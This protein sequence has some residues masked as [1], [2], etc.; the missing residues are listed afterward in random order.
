MMREQPLD[1]V[2]QGVQI[3]EVHQPD[4]A[5]AHL[6]F[7]SGPDATAGGADRGDR[8][9]RLAQRIKFAMQGQDERDVFGDAQIVRADGNPLRLQFCDLVQER[10]RIDDHTVAD[11]R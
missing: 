2:R 1:F 4:G 6:V 8:V 5:T 10:L 9:G 3:G 11:H 7:V